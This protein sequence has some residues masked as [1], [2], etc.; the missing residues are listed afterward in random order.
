MAALQ[1]VS[2]QLF[3]DNLDLWVTHSR[4]AE[5]PLPNG[6]GPLSKALIHYGKQPLIYLFVLFFYIYVICV[7][8]LSKEPHIIDNEIN[9]LDCHTQSLPVLQTL[10]HS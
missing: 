2:Q 10:A 8:L 4:L 5:I 9:I 3:G 7:W 6:S 1:Y